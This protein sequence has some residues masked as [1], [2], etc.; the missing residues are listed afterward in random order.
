MPMWPPSL[1]QDSVSAFMLSAGLSVRRGLDLGGGFRGLQVYGARLAALILLQIVRQALV[2]NEA[3]HA[4][5]LD[6]ADVNEGV[7]ATPV[8]L[9]EAVTLAL[10]EKFNGA[11][12]HVDVSFVGKPSVDFL[13]R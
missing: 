4:C 7:V 6:G 10:I 3:A 8:R 2:L 13:L 12:R 5:T 9:D 11:C 1:S